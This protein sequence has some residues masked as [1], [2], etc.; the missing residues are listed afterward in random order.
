M[1]IYTLLAAGMMS[2]GSAAP[3]ATRGL[4]G[5][6]TLRSDP[7][8]A[9][10]QGAYPFST[11]KAGTDLSG[12]GRNMTVGAGTPAFTAN[13]AAP[14]SSPYLSSYGPGNDNNYFTLASSNFNFKTQMTYTVE[15]W[16]YVI[17]G[18]AGAQILNYW[19]GFQSEGGFY[20]NTANQS[21]VSDAWTGY[22]CATSTGVWSFDTWNHTVYQR[23]SDTHEIYLN[24]T[25][26]AQIS[27][28]SYG[29]SYTTADV[30]KT[31]YGGSSPPFATSN[32]YIQD[33]RVYNVRKYTNSTYVLAD[34][35]PIL[36]S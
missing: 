2:T 11:S 14:S 18:S 8:S 17:T 21:I 3:A 22:S 13:P 34:V 12:L 31:R 15:C 5:D 4:V 26:L 24:G 6:G 29:A 36:N 30:L 19:S 23:Y 25:R 20:F 32:A 27:S 7:L 9:N 16:L 1:T 35:M 33:L 10:L 28:A